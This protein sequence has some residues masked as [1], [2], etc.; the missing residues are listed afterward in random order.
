[1]QIKHGFLLDSSE[2]TVNLRLLKKQILRKF[3][4]VLGDREYV[5]IWFMIPEM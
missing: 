5:K 2:G 1:M 4:I 3:V